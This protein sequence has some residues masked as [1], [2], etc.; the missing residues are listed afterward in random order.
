MH[1]MPTLT[2]LD[3]ARMLTRDSLLVQLRGCPMQQSQGIIAPIRLEEHLRAGEVHQRYVQ[4]LIHAR[5]MMRS[6]AL[7][8]TQTAVATM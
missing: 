2:S 4:A 3:E 7:K 5:I 8:L 1:A 6:G